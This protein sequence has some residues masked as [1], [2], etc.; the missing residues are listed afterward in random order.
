M[1]TV[2][3]TQTGKDENSIIEF[4]KIRNIAPEYMNNV[5][6]IIILLEEYDTFMNSWES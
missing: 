4:L 5:S 1:S 2:R 6:D 3:N